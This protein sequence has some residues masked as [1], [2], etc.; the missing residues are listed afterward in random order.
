MMTFDKWL[1]EKYNLTFDQLKHMSDEE[2]EKY[3]I[4]YKEYK[5]G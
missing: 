4:E 2:I 5:K 3:E 1:M